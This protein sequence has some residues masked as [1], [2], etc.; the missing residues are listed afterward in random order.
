M[1]NQ[2]ASTDKFHIVFYTKGSPTHKKLADIPFAVF[3]FY[4]EKI[5]IPILKEIKDQLKEVWFTLNAET[6][7]SK[8]SS[9]NTVPVEPIL[10]MKGELYL[11][12]AELSTCILPDPDPGVTFFRLDVYDLDRLI[13]TRHLT[14]EWLLINFIDELCKIIYKSE[15]EKKEIVYYKVVGVIQETG[16]DNLLNED[17]HLL[18]PSGHYQLPDVFEIPK[19]S[20]NRP[21][22]SFNKLK[23]D[24][25]AAYV[26]GHFPSA[27]QSGRGK[28]SSNRITLTQS[29]YDELCNTLPLSNTEENGGYLIGN[30]FR[31]PDSSPN[32][33]D[34]QFG[35]LIEITMIV[36]AE[37]AFGNSL[38][39]LFTGETWSRLNQRIDQEF[40]NQKLLGWYHTHLF[41]AS[42]KFGLSELD[43]SLHKQF[44]TRPWQVALLLNIENNKREL[45]SFQRSGINHRL[46]ET[47][48]EI[49][50]QQKSIF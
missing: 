43:Q 34:P 38:L 14:V 23:S 16:I 30:V 31:H 25:I 46:E 40:P 7:K 45:R 6:D 28:S 22:I 50:Q 29:L 39:L 10:T 21:K 19:P 5:A 18:L 47:K 35:W 24:S 42:D 4:A 2:I 11:R 27:E 8:L 9:L 13:I 32:E 3:A 48:F 15:L 33:D 20:G 41:A 49:I 44:F 37:Q 36:P 12:P 1:I 17:L 26:P